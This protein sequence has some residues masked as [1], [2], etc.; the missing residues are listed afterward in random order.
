MD[1]DILQRRFYFLS[2]INSLLLLLSQFKEA[3]IFRIDY[4]SI[5]G[6]YLPANPKK[7]TWK[8]LNACIGANSKRLIDEYTGDGVQ[9]ISRLLYQCENIKISDQSI[10]NRLFQQVIQNQGE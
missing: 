8:M 6:G 9:A 5:R 1:E 4:P 2:L 7:D 10:Y 3:Y